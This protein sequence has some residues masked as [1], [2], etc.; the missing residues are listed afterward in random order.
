[1][2]QR[3]QD[4]FCVFH[5]LSTSNRFRIIQ[6]RSQ[7]N[8][9]AVIKECQQLEK[10]LGYH[11]PKEA[12]SDDNWE[13]DDKEDIMIVTPAALKTLCS[14]T[15]TPLNEYDIVQNPKCAT[16]HYQWAYAGHV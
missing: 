8:E 4:R 11:T 12:D 1:M 7:K 5:T 14:S 6:C 10:E 13:S 3:L 15:L 9:A 16:I 2:S